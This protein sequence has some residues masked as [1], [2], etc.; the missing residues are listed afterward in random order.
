[1]LN[2]RKTSDYT[3]EAQSYVTYQSLQ[4]I[5]WNLDF[6]LIKSVALRVRTHGMQIVLIWALGALTTEL[7]HIWGNATSPAESFSIGLEAIY[8]QLAIK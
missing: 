5:G 2:I 7:S 3:F 6:L 1:M 4:K 8:L